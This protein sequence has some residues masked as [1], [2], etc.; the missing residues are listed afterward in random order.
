MKLLVLVIV[1]AMFGYF[2]YTGAKNLQNAKLASESSNPTKNYLTATGSVQVAL[3]AV[4]LLLAV[5]TF[6][7][8]GDL[9]YFFRV[10]H[11][12]LNPQ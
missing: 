2:L 8:Y 4:I 9:D 5:Y 7:K 10:I 3:A 12:F 1:V 6:K 11:G